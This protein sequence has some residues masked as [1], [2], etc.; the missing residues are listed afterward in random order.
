M[1]PDDL[2][3]KLKKEFEVLIDPVELLFKGDESNC[4][5][6]LNIF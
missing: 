1:L 2:K 5:M 4:L 3:Q 6:R